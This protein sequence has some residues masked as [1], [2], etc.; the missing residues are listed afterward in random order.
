LNVF[1]HPPNLLDLAA[2]D[3][4]VFKHLKQFSD[5]TCMVNNE[6]VKKLVKDWFTGLAADFYR[7][8]HAVQQVPDS[9]W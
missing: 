2:S 7:T 4:H 8:Y 5:G 1:F 3:F 6:E 9:S